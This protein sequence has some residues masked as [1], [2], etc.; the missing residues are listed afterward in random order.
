MQH[1]ATRT[2]RRT[3]TATTIHATHPPLP[4]ADRNNKPGASESFLVQFLAYY[5]FLFFGIM[6]VTT[7]V[8]KALPRVPGVVS[9]ALGVVLTVPLATP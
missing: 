9:A 6:T 1:H 3:Y 2:R 8:L 4:R 7:I 5:A